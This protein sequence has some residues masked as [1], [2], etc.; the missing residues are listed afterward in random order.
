MLIMNRAGKLIKSPV[1]SGVLFASPW[2]TGFLL[3][4]LF[5]ILASLYFSLCRYNVIRPPIFIGLVNYQLLL[6]D[7]FFWRSLW[8]TLYLLIFGLPLQLITAFL[9]AL[10][11]NSAIRGKGFFRTVFYLPSILPIVATA[12]LWLW[13][14][15]PRY[16]LINSL[17]SMTSDLILR[18]MGWILPSFAER[19]VQWLGQLRGPG[20]LADP[21]WSKPGLILMNLWLSGTT[22]VIFLAALQ[23]V[24]KHLYEAAMI[25]GANDF[26]KV[27]FVTIPS[28][29]PVILFNIVMGV[30]ATF[31]YFTQVYV[32]TTDPTTGQLAGGP[33][34]STLVYPLYLYQNAFQFFRMGYASAMAWIMF[35]IIG[36]CIWGIFKLYGRER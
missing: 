20:W 33:E 27:L 2:F 12:I 9:L 14:L 28:I 19:G 7:T 32:M 6:K 34:Y 1:F 21:A 26:Q 16:G 17:P 29:K 5:P 4:G 25:D 13:I 11:L 35:L 10:L 22:M 18:Y 15:N 30:I 3:L 8:N 23:Q 24:P 36:I 31:Q